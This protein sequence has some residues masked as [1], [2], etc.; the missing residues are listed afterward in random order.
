MQLMIEKIIKKVRIWIRYQKWK[1][2][3]VFCI[4]CDRMIDGK[5]RTIEWQE[6]AKDLLEDEKENE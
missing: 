4:E 3:A 1:C 2:P 5:C 6:F